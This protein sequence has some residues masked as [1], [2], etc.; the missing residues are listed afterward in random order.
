MDAGTAYSAVVTPGRRSSQ[1][2]AVLL[3]AAGVL[4]PLDEHQQKLA[5]F[6]VERPHKFLEQKPEKGAAASARQLFFA[7]WVEGRYSCAADGCMLVTIGSSSDATTATTAA[8]PLGVDVRPLMERA[9]G[10]EQ[11]AALAATWCVVASRPTRSRDCLFACA[12][13][14]QSV[15][16][17]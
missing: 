5:R 8:A 13:R 11:C 4:V 6:V 17:C 14:R 15:G 12:A 9:F 3:Q 10:I 2:H 1:E 7:S 16:V